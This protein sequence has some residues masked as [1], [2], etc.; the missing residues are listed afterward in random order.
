VELLSFGV[1][2]ADLDVVQRLA[3]G[4]VDLSRHLLEPAG[5][6]QLTATPPAL[7]PLLEGFSSAY[8]GL[9]RHPLVPGRQT[10]YV[11]YA[12]E[13]ARVR[14]IGRTAEQLVAWIFIRIL[15]SVDDRHT[16][17][18]WDALERAASALGLTDLAHFYDVTADGADSLYALPAFRAAPPRDASLSPRPGYDGEFPTLDEPASARRAAGSEVPEVASPEWL[19]AAGATAPW[20]GSGTPNAVFS[21]LLA[22]G[23]LGAAWLALNSP[24]WPIEPVER[25]LAELKQTSDDEGLHLL[26]EHWLARTDRRSGGY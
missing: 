11:E 26:A 15:E 18:R 16:D 2:T 4:S 17:R 8:L 20:I 13:T 21:D 1:P 9:W 7:T 3:D 14:E 5:N 22:T 6:E 24:R 10:S 19:S 25:A 23:D 12:W